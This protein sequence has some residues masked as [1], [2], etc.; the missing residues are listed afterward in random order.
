V[1]FLSYTVL[2]SV[3]DY[4]LHEY[5]SCRSIIVI[6]AILALFRFLVEISIL[7]F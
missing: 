5:G 4:K 3:Q 2:R 7:V 1:G 6:G